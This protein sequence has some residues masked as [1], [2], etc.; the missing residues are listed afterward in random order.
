MSFQTFYF[1]L[2]CLQE[3]PKQ[4]TELLCPL[5]PA[6]QGLPGT[7][8]APR[9]GKGSQAVAAGPAGTHVS[10]V[11]LHHGPVHVVGRQVGGGSEDSISIRGFLLLFFL[12]QK[13]NW[14][15]GNE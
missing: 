7:P 4:C 9:G 8:A 13:S 10:H 11:G 5:R 3:A 14:K 12:T 6:P 15:V 1:E 2:T